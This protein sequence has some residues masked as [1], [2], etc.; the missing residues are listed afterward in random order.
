MGIAISDMS[1]PAGRAP[2]PPSSIF[3]EA[4]DDDDDVDFLK[5]TEWNA[6]T[7]SAEMGWSVVNRMARPI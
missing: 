7:I 3:N 4:R 5:T 1:R 2:P 6:M